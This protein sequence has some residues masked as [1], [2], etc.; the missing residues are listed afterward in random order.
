VI[1]IDTSVWVRVLRGEADPPLAGEVQ[2]LLRE[3]VAAWCPL[4]EL[5]LWAGV[6][7]GDERSRL[8]AFREV[9]RSL[10]IEP[11]TWRAAI[12]LADRARRRGIT[13]PPSDLVIFACATQHRATLLHR[14]RHFELLTEL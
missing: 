1:L 11:A 6:R 4:V 5:E 13:V 9:L 10:A 14:D 12:D 8:S 3:G 2:T 7:D